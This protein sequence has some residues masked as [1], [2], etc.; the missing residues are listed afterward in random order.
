M[1]SHRLLAAALVSVLGL[2]A[3]HGDAHAI[4]WCAQPLQVHEWGV[5]VFGGDGAPG[6]G[7]PVPAWFHTAG[8]APKVGVPVRD[9]EP[10]SGERA[11]P[12]VHF[13]SATPFGRGAVPVGV[14]VGFSA[15]AALGHA[16]WP[17]GRPGRGRGRLFR[18]RR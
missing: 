10:D 18:R 6:A 16:L 9:L 14:E 3:P 1:N 7:V 17:R 11:L 8:D 2:A 12:V 15:G 4:S 5:H 13:Y